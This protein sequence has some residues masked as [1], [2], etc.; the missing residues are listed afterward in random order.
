MAGAVLAGA[1]AAAILWVKPWADSVMTA[2]LIISTDDAGPVNAHQTRTLFSARGKSRPVAE[3]ELD[4]GPWADQLVRLEVSGEVSQRAM[5]G[6]STGYVA[7]TLELVE[8]EGT[9]PL[10]FVG[11]RQGS[12][13]GLHIGPLGPRSFEAG[14]GGQM[15]FAVAPKGTLWYVLRVPSGARLRVRTRPI[16]LTDLPGRLEPFLPTEIGEA[17]GAAR[18]PRRPP[19]GAPDVFIYLIDALR[20]DHV[21]CY[22][23]ERD[24]SPAIDAFAAQATLYEQAQTAATWTRPSVATMLSG[25]HASVHG[26]MHESDLLEEWP[27][28]LPEM[29]QEAGYDTFCITTNGNIVADQ[30]FDQGYNDFIFL[31]QATAEWVNMM[32]GKILARHNPERPVFMYLHTVEPH[33]PY[34]PRAESFR[35]FDRGLSGRCDG[36]LESCE[37]VGILR[38]DLSDEDIAHLLDLYDGEVFDADQGFEDFLE[39]LRRTGRDENALIILVSDHGESFAEHDTLH[40]GWNLNQE[41]MRVVLAIRFPGGRF[42]GVRV[43]ERVSLVDVLPTVLAEVGVAPELEYSLPGRDLTSAARR[44]DAL[45]ARRI[46]GEVSQFDSNDL[47]LAAVIDEDGYKRVVDVSVPPQETATEKSIG[48]WDTRT[49]PKEAADLSESMPVRAAYGEQLIA[50]WLLAQS[51]WREQMSPG[52]PPTIEISDELREKLR[53][54]GY[55]RG[56]PRGTAPGPHERE[57]AADEG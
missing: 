46:Y 25:L 49:D 57:G 15:R 52:P 31:D 40:H 50:R 22:G 26:A 48:L 1:L 29:L 17:A 39:M 55:L 9:T 47:D 21:G 18:L 14:D 36:S 45:S 51:R 11:W 24:T 34:T 20:A 33:A 27:V 37:E 43:K 32:A 6:G 3:S 19:E 44:P 30:G 35:R 54:L 5:G 53:A 4:L 10:E 12:R 8:A 56:G 2:A 41:D 28:L 13:M 42:A 16:L 38:P 7:C 23:Y